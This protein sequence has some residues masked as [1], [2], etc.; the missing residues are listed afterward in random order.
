MGTT[1][2]A[3][4]VDD[5]ARRDGIGRVRVPVSATGPK[6]IRFMEVARSA[7]E[8]SGLE[9]RLADGTTVRGERVADLAA[10][11]RALRS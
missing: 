10:L 3:E 7:G 5:G 8:R 9:M 4:L 2:S 1:V 11:V 6:S